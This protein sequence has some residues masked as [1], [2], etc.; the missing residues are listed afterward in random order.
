[1]GRGNTGSWFFTGMLVIILSLP[2]VVFSQKSEDTAHLVFTKTAISQEK[3]DTY[4]VKKGDWIFDIIRKN[5]GGSE[6][7]IVKILQQVK[8]LN[9]KIKNLHKIAPGQKIVLPQ[10]N[11]VSGAVH[12]ALPVKKAAPQ[13]KTGRVNSSAQQEKMSPYVVKEGDS[14]SEIVQRELHASYDEIYQIM[15][16]VKRLNPNLTN[17]NSL[18]P[19]QKL[20]LPLGKKAEAPA[21]APK[22][23]M[24]EEKKERKIVIRKMTPEKKTAVAAVK[25]EATVT[26]QKQLTAL[27]YILTRVNGAVI[28]DGNYF[29]PLFPSGQ[30][31]INCPIVPV[32]EFDDGMTVLLD[33]NH[34]LPASLK[35]VVEATWKNYRIVRLG[36][37]QSLPSIVKTVI[38]ASKEYSFADVGTFKTV[39]STPPVKIFIDQI[40]SRQTRGGAKPYSFGIRSVE[41]RS[42]LLPADIRE[43][44]DREGFEIIELVGE[45]DVAGNTETFPDM[46]VP[47]LP[48]GTRQVLIESVLVALG[49]APERDAEVKIYNMKEHGFTLSVKVDLLVKTDTATVIL[50]SKKMPVEFTDVL[51]KKKTDVVF[52]SEKARKRAT[53]ERVLTAVRVPYLVDTFTFPF[54]QLNGKMGGEVVLSAIRVKGKN[55]LLYLS[56][57]E[58]DKSIYGLLNKKWGV[59]V[60]RY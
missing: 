60:A 48:S 18:Y 31:T 5:F 19:G 36:K 34:R 12:A 29:I 44:V 38:N 41:G 45:S 24:R 27:R 9:P 35:R 14:L 16:T 26:P 49:Y 52:I 53:I 55:G 40:V 50:H 4:V 33:V 1:M 47:V 58:I 2:S 8:H 25:V 15:R 56:S 21:I 57:R 6:K 51:K 43:Y 10:K 46:D 20:L 3:L 23:V 13:G 39:G 30:I 17:I 28:S 7:D 59:S 42:L 37:T 11:I 22:R 54:S 32:V